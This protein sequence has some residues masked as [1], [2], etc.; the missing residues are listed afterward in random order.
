MQI[1]AR[2]DEG[3][4]EGTIRKKVAR[5]LGKGAT[6]L[7][8]V[9]RSGSEIVYA[10]AIPLSEVLAIWIAQRDISTALGFGGKN[11]AMNGSSPTLWL[12]DDQAP[13]VAAA[14]WTHAGVRDLAQARTRAQTAS[15]DD[16][17]D[18]LPEA[19]YTSLG[20]DGALRV[21][22]IVSGVPRDPRVRDAVRLR[23]KNTCERAGCGAHRP[24]AGFI[25]VHH[26]LGA[27]NND[28][29]WTCVAL[30]PN[31]HREAH[32][33]PDRAQIN[34]ELL[35]FARQWAPAT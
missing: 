7:L 6:H 34:G 23:S 31:C 29:Y 24:Y 27:E 9:Q 18:D 14:L 26:I 1:S 25:D 11:H 28:R 21:E 5:Q 12:S 10:A 33:S 13:S 3:D 35:S 4:W 19:N 15:V 8:G 20:S 32:M 2:L 30:C 17:V 22:R 16:S